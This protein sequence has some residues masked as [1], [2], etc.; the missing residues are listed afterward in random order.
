MARWVYQITPHDEWDY[1][2]VNE[3]ILVDRAVDGFREKFWSISTA[4][5]LP[6]R[7]IGSTARRFRSKN[8]APMSISPQTGQ[9]CAPTNRICMD[10]ELFKAH[11]QLGLP[12]VGA[13]L[14]PPGAQDAGALIALNP[15]SG[16]RFYTGSH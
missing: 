10:Y 11:F 5:V 3:M 6:M 12:F 13:T 2:S 1:D 15:L 7:W 16:R 8:S 14:S 4:M 9:I